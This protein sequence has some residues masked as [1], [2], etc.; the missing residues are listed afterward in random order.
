VP[1]FTLDQ[2]WRLLPPESIVPA[3][4]Y[5]ATAPRS[6]VHGR[7][8]EQMALLEQL[9]NARESS[10]ANTSSTAATES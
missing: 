8:F 3:A 2:R 1:L 5:L 7:V 9:A 10:A 4:L 6:E